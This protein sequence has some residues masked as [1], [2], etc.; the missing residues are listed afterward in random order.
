MLDGSDNTD[1]KTQDGMQ[2][3]GDITGN[4]K[5]TIIKCKMTATSQAT[6]T[7]RTNAR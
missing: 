5:Q 6:K 4:K 2:D 7:N 1:K 3:A